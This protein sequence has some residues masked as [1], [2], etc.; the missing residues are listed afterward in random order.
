[1]S[2]DL[3]WLCPKWQEMW[4]S[5]T[6]QLISFFF[7]WP[8][9]QIAI[10]FVEFSFLWHLKSFRTTALKESKSNKHLTRKLGKGSVSQP[11]RVLGAP[12][13]NIVLTDWFARNNVDDTVFFFALFLTPG[14][15]L[16]LLGPRL[17]CLRS[18]IWHDTLLVSST[19]S[20]DQ[21]PVARGV[22]FMPQAGFDPPWFHY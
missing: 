18:N 15:G 2:F 11:F 8:V 16:P 3:K 7:N 14:A 21:D 5:S 9:Q 12:S 4:I 22:K 19:A 6:D 20:S 1:M 10:S 13:N 17:W